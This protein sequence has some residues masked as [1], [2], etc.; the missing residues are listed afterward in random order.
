MKRILKTDIP[1]DDQWHVVETADVRHVGQQHDDTTVT[2]WWEETADVR[3]RRLRVFGTGHEIPDD[4]TYVGTVQAS[5]GL[6]WHLIEEGLR[7]TV[8]FAPA[9]IEPLDVAAMTAEILRV[10]RHDL[11]GGGLA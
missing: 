4:T 6:V 9:V 2:F 5:N 7:P 10:V 8:T 1:I 11:R 3:A